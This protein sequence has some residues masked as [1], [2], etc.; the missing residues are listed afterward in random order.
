MMISGR[1]QEVDFEDR[2]EAVRR[3]LGGL[4]GTRKGGAGLLNPGPKPVSA[5]TPVQPMQAPVPR[6][7]LQSTSIPPARQQSKDVIQSKPTIPTIDFAHQAASTKENN[8]EMKPT[9]IYTPMSESDVGEK[10]GKVGATSKDA[11]ELLC[12]L[13]MT[14]KQPI[15][16]LATT[17][18]EPVAFPEP[19][20]APQ[21]VQ[22]Q[23]LMRRRR[24]STV[25]RTGKKKTEIE[26]ENDKLLD[27]LEALGEPAL[28]LPGETPVD[29]N[30]RLRKE[31]TAAMLKH[32]FFV[33]KRHTPPASTA[34]GSA[35]SGD[36]TNR[37]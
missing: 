18:P 15:R 20:P 1:Q 34:S 25:G 35:Y 32:S 3:A 5:T 4:V 27:E 17:N 9:E 23:G 22:R 30:Q 14:E 12:Q 2:A 6:F 33:K 13:R 24:D 29:M 28:E 11:Q 26:K 7:P 19:V 36:F 37:S 8:T 16:S 21:P 31:A 10:V